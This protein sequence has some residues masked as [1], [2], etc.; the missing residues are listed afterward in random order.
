MFKRR[1]VKETFENGRSVASVARD[2]GLNANMVF[3]WRRDPRFRVSGGSPLEVV[4]FMPIEL[5]GGMSANRVAAEGLRR[6]VRLSWFFS[7]VIVYGF[8]GVLI[9]TWHCAWFGFWRGHDSSSFKHQGL[10]GGGCHGHAQEFSW[11][12]SDCRED[13]GA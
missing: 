6:L 7:R 3:S 8:A 13:F 5:A 4:D 2:H 11:P 10:A 12:V 1:V 9:L